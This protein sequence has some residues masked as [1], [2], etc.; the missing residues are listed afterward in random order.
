MLRGDRGSRVELKDTAQIRQMRAAGR[1][2]AGTL[3]LV[4]LEARAGMSTAELD[5]LA[6]DSIR[7]AGAVPSFKGYYGF[8]GSICVSV[9]EEV[10]HGIPRADRVLATGDVLSVDCGA[11]LDGWHGD[12]AI[13]FV[14]GGPQAGTEQDR[15][16]LNACETAMW[17]GIAEMYPG[18]RLGDIGY[19][20]E[21]YVASLGDYGNVREYGGHGI[22][23][24]MH[25]EP[26][27]L[28]YGK[29][30]RGMRLQEG[31]CLAIEP[32]LTRGTRSVVP[33]DDGWTVVTEDGQP[34]AH[35]EHSVAVTADGPLVL[36]ARDE[37]R[38]TLARLGFRDP[39]DSGIR[40]G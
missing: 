4:R 40:V 17:R 18:N 29:R 16:H 6:E 28:N 38:E 15:A 31:M 2:V 25:M 33:L 12:S 3:D 36:T 30:R 8:T 39:D 10:V 37:N 35:F 23:S 26:H 32:M 19:A 14:V 21:S 34:A 20:I 11:I 13:T 24:E 9:N 22:G 7:S 27:V 5:A 1:V